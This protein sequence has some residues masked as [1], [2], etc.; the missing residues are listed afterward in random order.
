[1]FP[2]TTGEVVHRSY[3]GLVECVGL[4][5]LLVPS[6]VAYPSGLRGRFAKPLFAGSNPAATSK[7]PSALKGYSGRLCWKSAEI[8]SRDGGLERPFGDVRISFGYL[9]CS[10]PQKLREYL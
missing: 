4:C 6:R 8:Q 7:S 2:Y 10:M 9:G 3:K 5:K 1:M